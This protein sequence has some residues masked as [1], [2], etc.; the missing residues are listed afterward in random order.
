MKRVGLVISVILIALTTGFYACQKDNAN[1]LGNST[2]GIKIQALNKSYSLPVIGT[3]LKSA[4]VASASIAW[5]SARMVVSKV[6]FEAELKSLV[7]HRDSIEIDYKWNG[8]Q[9]ID[10]FDTNIILGR[11][12]LEPGFYD[13]IELKVEG[14][15][16]DTGVK[17]VFYL[18]G[19][20]NK[21]ATTAVP[22]RV[23]VKENV[24]FKTEKDSVEITVDD[25]IFSSIIQLYLDKLMADVQVSALDNATLTNGIIIISE[26][27]NKE[28]YRI[29]VRNLIKNHGCKFKKDHGKGD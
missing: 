19:I 11:F 28:L 5:D 14:N 12:T 25:P 22:I 4:S 21:D 16:Q 1:S 15:K 3:G 8:P 9:E 20:Y 2:L 29:I 23:W 24:L 10:L 27:S 26:N 6:I 17:P 7:S 18:H 13:E